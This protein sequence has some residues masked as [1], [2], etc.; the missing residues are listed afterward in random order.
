MKREKAV[1]ELGSSTAF[2]IADE[3]EFKKRQ[4]FATAPGALPSWAPVFWRKSTIRHNLWIS[5][6]LP[7]QDFFL[8]AIRRGCHLSQ[9]E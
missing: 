5:K 8:G 9:F 2:W 4:C 6:T 7:S 3:K 1:E